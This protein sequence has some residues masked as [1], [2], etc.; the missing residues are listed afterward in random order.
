MSKSLFEQYEEQRKFFSLGTILR[1]RDS[2][3]SILE[4]MI[5]EDRSSHRAGKARMIE[6]LKVEEPSGF[7]VG[8]RIEIADQS[9][10]SYFTLKGTSND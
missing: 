10:K 1:R 9:I 6:V 7:Y 4:I 8:E 3:I 2:W 5:I